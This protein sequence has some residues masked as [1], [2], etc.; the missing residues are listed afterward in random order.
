MV[1]NAR[2]DE[3]SLSDLLYSKFTVVQQYE[4]EVISCEENIK[5]YQERELKRIAEIREEHSDLSETE[6]SEIVSNDWRIED[7][8]ENIR[9]CRARIYIL[10]C[11]SDFVVNL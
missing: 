1:K 2:F 3:F 11:I 6:I 8:R 5:E 9:R 4:K 7:L 10:K